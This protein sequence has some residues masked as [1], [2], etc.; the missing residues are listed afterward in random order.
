MQI[1]FIVPVF[2]FIVPTVTDTAEA[3]EHRKYA[4]LLESKYFLN[5]RGECAVPW[6]MES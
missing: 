3:G 2:F 5:C 1:T 6:Q 4:S